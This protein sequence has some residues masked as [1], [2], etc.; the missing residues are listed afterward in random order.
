MRKSEKDLAIR[1]THHASRI[2]QLLF[3]SVFC[4]GTAGAE[5]DPSKLPPAAQVTVDFEKDV[6]PIF[7]KTC[8]RCHGP[9]RPKS[10]FRLD[11]RESALKR[12]DTG[13]DVVPGDSAKS[14]LV[15]YVARVVEDM[16]MPPTGKGEPLTKEQV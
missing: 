3:A 14:P 9:E 6:K 2:T 7:E 13:I 12:G 10:G 11:N 8:F 4:W 16:E 5:L 15:Y 1:F